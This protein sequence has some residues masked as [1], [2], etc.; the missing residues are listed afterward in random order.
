MDWGL[1]VSGVWIPRCGDVGD[2]PG[3]GGGVVL[4]VLV[5]FG[6]WGLDTLALTWSKLTLSW[7]GP[8]LLRD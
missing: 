6:G 3:D 5:V 7:M 1:G 4:V 8:G 2:I